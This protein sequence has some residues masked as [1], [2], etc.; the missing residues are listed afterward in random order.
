MEIHIIWLLVK[1]GYNIKKN[2]FIKMHIEYVNKTWTNNESNINDE[3]KCCYMYTLY[4]LIITLG[5]VSNWINK[6]SWK[7]AFVASACCMRFMFVVLSTFKT[8]INR[9]VHVRSVV[10]EKRRIDFV[11]SRSIERNEIIV[12]YVGITWFNPIFLFNWPGK[13]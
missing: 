10:L 6:I 13:W 9:T 11:Q 1:V 12:S 3:Y 2:I 8:T 5:L 7:F 4:V